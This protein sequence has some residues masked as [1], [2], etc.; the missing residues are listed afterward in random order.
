MNHSIVIGDEW[1]EITD[2]KIVIDGQW[3]TVNTIQVV[4]E[5]EW[6]DVYSSEVISWLDGWA[7]RI[8]ITI[9]KDQI[10]A[11]LT[12]FPVP[13]SL[14]QSAGQDNYDV[15]YIFDE[16]T[17][18]ANRKKI[19]VATSDG[20]TQCYVEIEDWADTNE[21]AWLH[22]N[23]PFISS[24]TDTVLYLYYDSSHTTN[25]GF[26]GDP[27][28]PIV[29]NVWNSDFKR[30]WHLSQDPVYG[31]GDANTTYLNED[32]ANI[33]DWTQADLGNGVSRQATFDSKSCMK[34]D[35]GTATTT[36][37]A[38]RWRDVG[39]FG[40][41]VVVE[42]SVYLDK[43][44]DYTNENYFKC[45]IRK[46]TV[47]ADFVL[48]SEG[49]YVQSASGYQ[50]IDADIVLEDVWQKWVFDIDFTTPVSSTADIYLDD[51]LKYSNVDCVREVSSTEGLVQLFSLVRQRMIK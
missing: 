19:A 1:K 37:Y 41:R 36:N 13:I 16:L 46:S 3:K 10:D 5:N 8:K 35:T 29:Q 40:N 22:V 48:S 9:D 44:G 23:V 20:E 18:D 32:M 38:N 33:T 51:V 17:S 21:K 30:V 6:K 2:T 43:A 47:Q 45:N 14:S 7:Y 49:L 39:T 34:L 42:L 4:V 11:D 24:S 28:N 26:V 31:Y 12:N 27:G 50:L 25:S 15:S